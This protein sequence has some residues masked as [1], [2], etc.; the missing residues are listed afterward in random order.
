MHQSFGHVTDLLKSTQRIEPGQEIPEVSAIII[1]GDSFGQIVDDLRQCGSVELY[2]PISGVDADTI[3]MLKKCL[4]YKGADP[5]ATFDNYETLS[6]YIIVKIAAGVIDLAGIKAIVDTVKPGPGMVHRETEIELTY[7]RIARAVSDWYRNQESALCEHPHFV[8][9]TFVEE[10]DEQNRQAEEATKSA[11]KAYRERA[12][13]AE[14]VEP[15][16]PQLMKRMRT[17]S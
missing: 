14:K 1:K 15:D 3:D 12:V 17:M 10:L 16:A 2:I 7:N 9:R 8:D 13:A 4:T 5:S 6:C 11:Q